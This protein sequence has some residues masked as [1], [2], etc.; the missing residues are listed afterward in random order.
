MCS[1]DTKYLR[2]QQSDGPHLVNTCTDVGRIWADIML[3][4]GIII[5]IS[6]SIVLKVICMELYR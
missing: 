2:Q 1:K 6:I 3:L 5:K 4:S